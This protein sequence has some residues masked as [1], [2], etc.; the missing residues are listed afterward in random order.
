MNLAGSAMSQCGWELPGLLVWQLC[1]LPDGGDAHPLMAVAVSSE[2]ALWRRLPSQQLR[3][4]PRPHHWSRRE[5]AFM[6]LRR[7]QRRLFSV[8]PSSSVSLLVL[9]NK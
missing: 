5:P 9:Q 2:L 3:S 6:V 4:G 7:A 1:F 8:P